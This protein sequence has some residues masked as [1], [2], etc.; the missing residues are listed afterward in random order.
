MATYDSA[1]YAKTQFVGSGFGNLTANRLV[2]PGL[3]VVAGSTV[4]MCRLP[5]GII[6]YGFLVFAEAN[7]GSSTIAIETKEDGESKVTR[8]AAF[9]ISSA[10]NTTKLLALPVKITTEVDLQLLT[11]GATLTADDEITIVPLFNHI[12]V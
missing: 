4:R 1:S 9:S 11:A 2:Y 6:L 10:V 5:A 8:V 3:A 7:T 12:G